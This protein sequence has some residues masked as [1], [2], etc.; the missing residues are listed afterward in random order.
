MFMAWVFL[1]TSTHWPQPIHFEISLIMAL[2]EVSA[3]VETVDSLSTIVS[4]NTFLPKAHRDAKPAALIAWYIF[5]HTL[6][7]LEN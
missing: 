1:Q 7:P 5:T 6:P 2:L 3:I 4:P